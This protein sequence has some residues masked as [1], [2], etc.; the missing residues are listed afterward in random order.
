MTRYP[1]SRLSSRSARALAALLAASLGA[2]PAALAGP[3]EEVLATELTSTLGDAVPPDATVSLSLTVPFDGAVDAVRDITYDS[4]TG[5]VRALVD[6][7]GIIRE[8]HARAEV[9]VPVPVPTRRI[10]LGEIIAESDLTTI[11]MPLGRVGDGI[12]VSRDELIGLESRRLLSPGRLI[13]ASSVGMPVMVKRNKPV[14]IVFEDGLLQLAAKG[15]ALQD[16]GVGDMVRVM[17][18]ASSVVVTG[19]V[20]GPQTVSV[21]GTQSVSPPVSPQP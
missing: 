13:Q 5:S 1:L 2:A 16:G 12:V 19:T 17:N 11:A 14:T 7:A 20:S 15:R 18:T 4:R 9:S 3:V 21:S 6:S 10:G 8:L